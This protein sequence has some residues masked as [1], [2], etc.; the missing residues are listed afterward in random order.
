[1]WHIQNTIKRAIKTELRMC[2]RQPMRQTN[3]TDQRASQH[4]IA[5]RQTLGITLSKVNVNLETL[6]YHPTPLNRRLDPTHLHI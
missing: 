6:S 1:M 5:N 4:F 2:S 3:T